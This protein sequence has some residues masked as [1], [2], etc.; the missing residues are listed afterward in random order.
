MATLTVGPNSSFP[1]IAAAMAAANPG[2]AIVLESGY[3]NETAT[4]TVNNLFVN[5][6]PSSTNIAL[7]LAPGV[8]AL[9]LQ[10]AAPIAVTDNAGNNT[11][12][13]NSGDN[14]ITVSGGI[15]SVDGGA[16]ADRLIVDYSADTLGVAGTSLVTGT[17]DGYQGA[18]SD[19]ISHVV[20]FN[21]VDSFDVRTGSGNDIITTGGR[22]DVITVTGG[23][24][25]V[26][27]AGGI[28][29]LVVNYSNLTSNFISGPLTTGTTDGFRGTYTGG[30]GN[31]VTF[32][33]IENFSI[34]TGSGND[35]IVT[36][37]GDDVL[38]GGT[39]TD[40]MS[41]GAANDLYF[42]DNPGDVVTENPSAGID[43]ETSTVSRTLD[44]NVENLILAGAGPI[45]GTGN[46]LGNSI[47]G[48]ASDNIIDGAAG[49]DTMA[50][51][52]GNDT[53]FIDNPGDVVLED[54]NAGTDTEIASVSRTLDANVENLT[55]AAGAGPINGTGNALDNMIIGNESDNI[56]DGGGGSDT[57]IGGG[58]NDTLILS[59]A[60]ANYTV[61]ALS[62][63]QFQLID[64]RTNATTTISGIEAVQF[65]DRTIG[66]D[67]I[68]LDKVTI[69]RPVDLNA[70]S[71]DDLIWHGDT[72]AVALWIS[73][74]SQIV[75]PPL[76]VGTTPRSTTIEGTGD[77]NGD[78]RGDILFHNADGH[79]A[80]WFMNGN[81]ID[82]IRDLGSTDPTW[83]VQATGDFNGDHNDDILFRSD[84]GQLATWSMQGGQLAST[85]T[86]GS[87]GAGAHVQGTGD[88]NGDGRSD[89]LFRSDDGHVVAWLMNNGQ[90]SAVVDLGTVSSST[91]IAGTGDFNGDGQTDILF[92]SNDGHVTAWLMTSG[93]VASMQDTGGTT[94]P[95]WQIQG[96]ADVNGDGRDDILWHNIVDQ[97][98]V[99]AWL[100][101]GNG[102]LSSIQ[103]LGNTP[104]GNH[105][106]G[107]QYD[108]V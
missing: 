76:P 34:T 48:N 85:Q 100:L 65:S 24:D 47:T 26:E 56:L 9:T 101:N 59:G 97:H 80:A 2:D 12:T 66:I 39:G 90:A 13:A 72:G 77:F 78:G 33:D 50:G 42:I 18:Y 46:G 38:N 99:A 92:R 87:T 75:A 95:F 70:D 64:N 25:A 43:T 35:T 62:S 32:D 53:Y 14:V 16:G 52:A 22:D 19:L 98:G 69:A 8:S 6:A 23:V 94:S 86:A 108:L 107:G 29:R 36:A 55:L 91:Q 31:L 57:L 63:T 89:I 82:L 61:R 1:T 20:T 5:G 106:G 3:S 68:Q 93:H 21:N 7:Q 45:N 15:D 11:I 44:A 17:V 37:G 102:Q 54:P 4:V 81:H 60:R 10:G 103:D 67:S 79:I 41:G 74:G 51:A 58:G 30:P 84:A 73:N 88:F 104:A 40:S 96:T 27:G 71:T 83:H 105:L 49:A 28:D